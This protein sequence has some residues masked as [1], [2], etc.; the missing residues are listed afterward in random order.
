MSYAARWCPR[1][2]TGRRPVCDLTLAELRAHYGYAVVGEDHTI[3]AR[4]PVLE[5]VVRWARTTRGSRRCPR[6]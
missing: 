2:D 1:Q 3:P 4:L 5:E 6:L